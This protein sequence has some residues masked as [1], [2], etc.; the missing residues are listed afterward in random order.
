MKIVKRAVLTLAFN[1]RSLIAECCRHVADFGRSSGAVKKHLV[2]V[3]KRPWHGE[4]QQ[5]ETADIARRAGACVVEGDWYSEADQRN[6]GLKLLKGYDLVYVLD[7]DERMG[8]IAWSSLADSAFNNKDAEAFSASRCHV[9][10]KSINYRIVPRQPEKPVMAVRPSVRFEHARRLAYGIDPC[11]VDA[12]E[13]W[14]LS[15]VRDDVEMAKK[16]TTFEHA[17]EFDTARWYDEVWLKWTPEMRNLH[18][19][20]PEQFHAAVETNAPGWL[21]G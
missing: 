12:C 17:S 11:V 1:E 3:S 7:A 6:H 15:Y 16:I 14:H 10:W 5:D 20:V 4:W 18:P 21:T 9:F 19:V 8:L 2:L 13:L